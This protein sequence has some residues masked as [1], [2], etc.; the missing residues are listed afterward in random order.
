MKKII[1]L[2]FS[3]LISAASAQI[4]DSTVFE[5]R[6]YKI[7][8]GQR[9][10][11]IHLFKNEISKLIEKHQM[12]FY[13]C[14]TDVDS[15]KVVY[16]VSHINK[17]AMTTSWKNFYADPA[18]APIKEKLNANEKTVLKTTSMLL[19]YSDIV[20]FKTNTSDAKLYE[21][22]IY[23][24]FPG[25]LPN[26]ITRFKTGTTRIFEKN[27]MENIT[28][29]TTIEKSGQSKLV[30]FVAHKDKAAQ[31]ASWDSFGKDPDWIRH[32]NQSEKDGKIV[33]RVE[34]LSLT[35]FSIH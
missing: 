25:R 28:Y 27:G 20:P 21:L 8:E 3:F 9:E 11:F 14:W 15:N 17:V 7:A 30:Y 19:R 23:Y 18:W 16:I 4:T 12:K 34:S 26:L 13:G 5:L 22:R 29:W 24:C 35:P 32:R 1:V 10:S 33:E 2:V 31:K 6:I